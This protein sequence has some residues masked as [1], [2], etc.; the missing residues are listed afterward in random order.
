MPFVALFIAMF[1]IQ[2]GASC[3]KHLFPA[4]GVAGVSFLR[5]GFAAL[6]LLVIFKPW[7]IK[8]TLVQWKMI[9]GYGLSLGAMNFT[10]YLSIRD[11]PLGIAVACE[12]LGPL[13]LSIFYSKKSKDFFW[14]F[15]A[16]F[17]LLL[18]LP[19]FKHTAD[20]HIN[21]ILYA[22]LAGF[23]WALYIVFGKKAVSCIDGGSV[24]AV[25]MVIASLFVFPFFCLEGSISLLNSRIFFD[26]LIVAIFSSALPY[27]LE[28]IGLR[29]IPVQTFGILMSLEPVLAGLS[30][31]V[32]LH[33]MLST[34]QW[35]GIICIMIASFGSSLTTRQKVV[36]AQVN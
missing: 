5:T 26:G 33:E 32:L 20:V 27:S 13:L 22:L 31:M 12:F 1:S 21:G 17:G 28:M 25:G 16:A 4:L 34:L 14:V 9:L 3:A 19:L 23:F 7:K 30:G 15:L 6:I 8:L 11:I 18:V 24:T 35:L 36:V 29:H 10:F 2:A